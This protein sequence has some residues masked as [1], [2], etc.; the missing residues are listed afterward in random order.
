MKLYKLAKRIAN[1]MWDMDPYDMPYDNVGEL[2]AKT[3][4]DLTDKA[5]RKAIIQWL[6]D[7]ETETEY[8]QKLITEVKAI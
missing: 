4:Q 6:T 3:L 7:C 2:I 8:A 5:K 1:F